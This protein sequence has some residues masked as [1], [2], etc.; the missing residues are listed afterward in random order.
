M[1]EWMNQYGE[2]LADDMV[3]LLSHAGDDHLDD[4]DDDDDNRAKKID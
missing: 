1:P 3:D 2:K 4:D